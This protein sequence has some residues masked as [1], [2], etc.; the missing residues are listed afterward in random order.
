MRSSRSSGGRRDID[1][2][3]V[4][5][6]I[7][8]RLVLGRSLISDRPLPIG[9]NPKTLFGPGSSV[10]RHRP[11]PILRPRRLVTW[12][13]HPF[14]DSYHGEGMSLVLRVIRR[15]EKT[16]KRATYRKD[17][18]LQRCPTPVGSHID[19]GVNNRVIPPALL[20][21]SAGSSAAHGPWVKRGAYDE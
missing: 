3:A 12:P 10:L 4:E 19:L 18:E 21:V 14:F 13:V 7:L 9:Y 5:I 8:E 11:A 16:G 20:S 15:W 1:I 2:V 17:A 6:S